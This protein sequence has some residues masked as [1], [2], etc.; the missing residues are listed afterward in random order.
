MKRLGF[1]RACMTE[2]S[3][4]TLWRVH[5]AGLPLLECTSGAAAAE[6][7][8]SH[9]KAVGWHRWAQCKLVL[10]ARGTA[11]DV[12][13]TGAKEQA[14]AEEEEEHHIVQVWRLHGEE[15]AQE[16]AEFGEQ[17]TADR[18]LSFGMSCVSKHA[19]F[20]RFL[21][22]P[23]IFKHPPLPQVNNYL[24][25]RGGEASFHWQP[26]SLPPAHPPPF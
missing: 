18:L 4:T 15:G 9:F 5:T 25:R 19:P 23:L 3:L 17:H 21:A 10:S 8:A 22:S 12:V 6:R 13:E 20:I 16:L 2:E 7:L 26:M 11:D 24:S 14:R 1:P